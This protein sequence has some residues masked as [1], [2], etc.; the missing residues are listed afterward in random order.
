VV[1]ETNYNASQQSCKDLQEKL[2]EQQ[3]CCGELEE[4]LALNMEECSAINEEKVYLVHCTSHVK[5][6]LQLEL[7]ESVSAL[8]E[9][10]EKYQNDLNMKD[11]QVI[12]LNTQLKHLQDVSPP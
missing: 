5:C 11:E 1:S 9:E 4:K 6:I 10:L 8:T 7:E 2:V 3:Q 12:Q